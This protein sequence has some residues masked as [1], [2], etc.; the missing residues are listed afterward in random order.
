[1]SPLSHLISNDRSIPLRPIHSNHTTFHAY[2]IWCDVTF[3]NALFVYFLG[4]LE[5]V[6]YSWAYVDHFHFVFLRDGWIRT[7]R[8]AVASRHAT[9]LATHLPMWPI[10][11]WTSSPSILFAVFGIFYRILNLP[12]RNQI[13]K[14]YVIYCLKVP[15][16]E[17]FDR[18][19]FHY[20]YT[21]KPFWLDE[22]VV[23]ILTYYSNF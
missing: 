12:D 1:M 6:G 13:W 23:K 19:D 16:C 21:I 17:I 9:N 3:N 5:C 22:F 20:F 8:A 15:K 4:G 14:F 10:Q 7:Q 2:L 11:T 18:S